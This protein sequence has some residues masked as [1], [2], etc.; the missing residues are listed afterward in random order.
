MTKRKCPLWIANAAPGSSDP[1]GLTCPHSSDRSIPQRDCQG[2]VGCLGQLLLE[3]LAQADRDRRPGRERQGLTTDVNAWSFPE[4][5]RQEN[6]ILPQQ[7]E[8]LP[9]AAQS[10]LRQ[11]GRDQMSAYELIDAEKKRQEETFPSWRCCARCLAAACL[12]LAT[13]PGGTEAAVQEEP[14]RRRRSHPYRE[15][16]RDPQ[17]QQRRDLPLSPGARRSALLHRGAL[18]A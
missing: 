18:R 1:V 15:D 13:T 5:L 10:L 9:K 11:R 14:R 16:P 3:K 6:R 7:R 12:A 4:G 8:I 17:A 2:G